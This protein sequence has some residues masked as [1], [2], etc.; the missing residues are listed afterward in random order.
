MTVLLINDNLLRKVYSKFNN[1][2]NLH[3]RKLTIFISYIMYT[4]KYWKIL[5][6]VEKYRK[7]EKENKKSINDNI[8][9][10]KMIEN[11]FLLLWYP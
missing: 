6:K 1:V 2:N 4:L 9:A 3:V 7:K 5:M 10:T 8:L 11:V